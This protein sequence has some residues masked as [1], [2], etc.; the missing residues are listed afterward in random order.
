MQSEVTDPKLPLGWGHL[1]EKGSI[2]GSSFS[3]A[4]LAPPPI[5]FLVVPVLLLESNELVS[6]SEHGHRYQEVGAVGA[7]AAICF[8]VP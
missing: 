2:S 7:S 3:P 4:C 1:N 5:Q 8:A 6:V